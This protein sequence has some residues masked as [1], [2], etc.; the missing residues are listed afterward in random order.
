MR[1]LRSGRRLAALAGAFVALAAGA[2][3]TAAAPKAITWTDCTALPG[4]TE[5]PATERARLRCGTLAVPIDHREPDGRTFD[6]AFAVRAAERPAGR[7][8]VL[9]LSGSGG[10]ALRQAARPPARDIDGEQP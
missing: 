1:H 5:R 8:P 4:Y 3:A 7:P 9:V 6:L 2:P 10:G